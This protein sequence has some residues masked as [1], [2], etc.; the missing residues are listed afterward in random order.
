MRAAALILAAV[1]FLPG[2]A[3]AATRTDVRT[4]A[5]AIV[6]QV[7]ACDHPTDAV[8]LAY[9]QTRK[10]AQVV[11]M[12]TALPYT[13]NPTEADVRAMA[14]LIGPRTSNT[15]LLAD[16]LVWLQSAH[17]TLTAAGVCS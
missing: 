15:R 11:Q 4:E 6:A 13:A 2:T 10:G 8:R 5:Q 14:S 17:G 12:T 9:L 7:D 3:S 1:A 16:G